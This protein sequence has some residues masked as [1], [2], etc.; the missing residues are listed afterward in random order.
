MIYHEP[1]D[2]KTSE[3]LLKATKKLTLNF[4]FRKTC[5]P[6]LENWRLGAKRFQTGWLSSLWKVR[7]LMSMAP[8]AN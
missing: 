2:F 6:F 4:L 3:E 1:F 8:Q 5:L 7:M